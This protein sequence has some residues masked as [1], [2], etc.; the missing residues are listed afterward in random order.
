MF[1]DGR[2]LAERTPLTLELRPGERATLTLAKG[3]WL[4]QRV[5]IVGREDDQQVRVTL[6]RRVWGAPTSEPTEGD[7]GLNSPA[8]GS[9]P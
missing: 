8:P 6:R 7:E 3:G 5:T 4:D 9:A 1:R 2:R